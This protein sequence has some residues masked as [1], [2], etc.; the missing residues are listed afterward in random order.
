MAELWVTSRPAVPRRGLIVASVLFGVAL[1]LAWQM[2]QTRSGRLLAA[3]VDSPELDL[4]FRPPRGF[5]GGDPV[6]TRLGPALPFHG[7]CSAGT[8]CEMVVRRLPRIADES[9]AQ[10]CRRMLAEVTPFWFRPLGRVTVPASEELLGPWMG[11]QVFE[12]RNQVLIRAATPSPDS[13]VVVTLTANRAKLGEADYRMFDR[14]CRSVV[15]LD[16]K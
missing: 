13:A 6:M 5:M 14:V 3:A 16:A 8:D 1:L 15:S 10:V 7:V 11:V 4:R 2:A 12:Q 9:A